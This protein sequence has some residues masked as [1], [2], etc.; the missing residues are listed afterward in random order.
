MERYGS[1]AVVPTQTALLFSSLNDLKVFFVFL[2]AL[3]KF[4]AQSIIGKCTSR[5]LFPDGGLA[6]R[7]RASECL[8]KRHAQFNPLPRLNK[9][10]FNRGLFGNLPHNSLLIRRGES[11]LEHV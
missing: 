4:R 2:Y 9:P 6:S 3:L 7:E 11:R 5:H 8:N 10:V 1:M